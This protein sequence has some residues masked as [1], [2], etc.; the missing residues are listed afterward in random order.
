MKRTLLALAGFVA[1]GALTHAADYTLH[2]F[3]RIQL[4]DQFW[5][6][7]AYHGDFNRDGKPDVCGGPFWWP[8]RLQNAHEFRPA[9]RLP[10]SRSPTAP[11]SPSPATR[12]PWATRMT[13]R[14]IS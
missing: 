10:K 6:E 3:N 8:A 5:C 1:G 4:T 14:T 7:G 2:R 12:A 9:P 11:K 13:T